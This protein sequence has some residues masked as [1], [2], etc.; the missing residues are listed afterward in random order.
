VQISGDQW[1]KGPLAMAQS[2]ISRSIPLSTTKLKEINSKQVQVNDI[3]SAT[4][5]SILLINKYSKLN[6][7]PETSMAFKDILQLTKPSS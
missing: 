3:I 5:E 2:D 4:I 7:V 6:C 1:A